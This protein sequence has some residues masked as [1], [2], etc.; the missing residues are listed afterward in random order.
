VCASVGRV[1][2]DQRQRNGQGKAYQHVPC[3]EATVAL[4]LARDGHGVQV[5]IVIVVARLVQISVM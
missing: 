3:Q 5:A 4:V 1:R 2:K